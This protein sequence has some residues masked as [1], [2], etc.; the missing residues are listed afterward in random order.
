MGL[1]VNQAC[2][3]TLPELFGSLNIPDTETQYHRDV[4][5]YCGGPLHNEQGLVLHT[6]GQRQWL[7]TEQLGDDLFVSSSEDIWQDI[8]ANCGPDK[9]SII[10]GLSSWG[11]GQL[12]EE[13]KDNAWLTSMANNDIIFSSPHQQR[14]QHAINTLGFSPSAL[15]SIAGHA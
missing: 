10:L 12:E 3:L 2:Q 13:I 8:A 11:P 7:G 6:A 5:V 9:F 1:V 4:P 14:W 15:S